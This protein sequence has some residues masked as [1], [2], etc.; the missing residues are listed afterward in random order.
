MKKQSRK[1]GVILNHGATIEFHDSL[2]RMLGLDVSG[3]LSKTT[4]GTYP[5]DIHRG[6]YTFYVYSDLVT[7]QYIGD[8]VAPLLRNVDVDHT[9]IGGMFCRTYNTPHYI[10]VI[11][12]NIETIKVDIRSDTGE[13][14]PFESGRVICKLHFRLKRSSYLL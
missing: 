5:V 8:A 12:K 3:K 6:F 14:I 13:L 1:F 9:K 7:S 11:S 2:S 4:V 10:P